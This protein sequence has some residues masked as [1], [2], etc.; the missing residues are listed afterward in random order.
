MAGRRHGRTDPPPAALGEQPEERGRSRKTAAT[1]LDLT[2]NR[3]GRRR[4]RPR[5]RSSRRRPGRPGGGG[6]PA[7]PTV[8]A[9]RPR[10]PVRRRSRSA[11]P[12]VGRLDHGLQQHGEHLGGA[13]PQ[14]AHHQA[15]GQIQTFPAPRPAR[16]ARTPPPP[17]TPPTP[18]PPERPAP[19]AAADPRPHPPPYQDEYPIP[20]AGQKAATPPQ[21]LPH[22]AP[23]L[24]ADLSTP[25]DIRSNVRI[26]QARHTCVRLRM[27]GRTCIRYL[28]TGLPPGASPPGTWFTWTSRWPGPPP[29][30]WR[31]PPRG[32]RPVRDQPRSG[33]SRGTA[34]T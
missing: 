16:P 17:P 10:R 30:F 4:W 21:R 5:S 31:H 7:R 19:A 25:F 23:R 34:R 6:T 24:P 28:G 33:S 8:P 15:G 1:G 14:V 29:R 26:I 32:R 22:P 20:A 2:Q 18:Q 12:A 27:N 9:G 3:P 11:G 13:R